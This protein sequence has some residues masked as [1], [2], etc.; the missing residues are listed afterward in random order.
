MTYWHRGHSLRT[1][2]HK[3]Q[4]AP[5]STQKQ[6]DTLLLTASR[7]HSRSANRRT[8]LLTLVTMLCSLSAAAQSYLGAITGTIKDPSGASVDG[9]Q[10]TVTQSGT[11]FVTKIQ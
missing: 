1:Q 7:S 10:I 11:N 9:A 5:L 6:Y 8:L 3:L 2:T 4:E